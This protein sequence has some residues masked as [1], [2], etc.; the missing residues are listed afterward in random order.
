MKEEK[1]MKKMEDRI[2]KKKEN[3]KWKEKNERRE[4]VKIT[5]KK[6]STDNRGS[7]S[8]LKAP[9]V[10]KCIFSPMDFLFG[11]MSY[12]GQFQIRDNVTFG[13]LSYSG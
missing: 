11:K 9:D 8:T 4:R 5:A 12:S 1:I 13:T 3:K 7:V 6:F 10:G 2:R